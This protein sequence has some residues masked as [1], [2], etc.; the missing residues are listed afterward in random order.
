M[1]DKVVCT[2]EQGRFVGYVRSLIYA[3]TS[4]IRLGK[5]TRACLAGVSLRQSVLS[6][7]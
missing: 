6:V 4:L 7:Q 2:V 1:G 3:T 5:A